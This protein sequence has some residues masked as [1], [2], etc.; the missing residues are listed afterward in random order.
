MYSVEERFLAEVEKFRLW[1][2]AIPE[3]QKSLEWEC[4]YP[5]WANVY[6]AVEELL[7]T[8]NLEKLRKQTLKQLLY[9]TAADHSCQMIAAR[10]ARY[11]EQL[12]FLAH[13]ALVSTYSDA[14]WQIAVELG[15]ITVQKADAERLLLAFA[16]D[17]DEYTRRRALGA[18]AQANSLLV[19]EVA[20]TAW[21]SNHEYQRIM[22]LSALH[23]VN[24]PELE[25]YLTLA[26]E[27][28]REYVVAQ[29][30]HIRRDETK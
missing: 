24:S 25:K 9:I 10:I 21:L 2:S 17:E 4:D 12:L 23:K 26:D 1:T 14:K 22:A 7:S 11:P 19:N 15:K 18:L 30:Q 28:G 8:V 13:A 3:E 16:K 6:E 27:D 5:D 29:A 20:A